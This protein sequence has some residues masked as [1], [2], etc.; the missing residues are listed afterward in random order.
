M[1]PAKPHRLLLDRV[2][3]YADEAAAYLRRRRHIRKPFARVYYRGGRSFAFPADT[4]AGRALFLAAS[5]LVE[6]A[7]PSR[8]TRQG[9]A[10]STAT[11]QAR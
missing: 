11:R 3:S 5:R 8:R 2:S 10:G 4:E 7:P 9:R 1:S 6:L